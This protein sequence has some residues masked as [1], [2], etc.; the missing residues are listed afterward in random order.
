MQAIILA[1]GLGTRLREFHALPKGFLT[2][3]GQTLVSL[4][5]QH[6]LNQTIS[7][8]LIITGYGFEHYNQLAK[9]HPF[10]TTQ[11]NNRFDTY[12]NLYSLFLAKDWV[13]QDVLILESD[14]LYESR[15]LTE[16]VDNSATN[17]ILTSGFTQSGDEV[18]V[19]ALDQALTNMSKNKQLLAGT[20][21]MGEFVGITKLCVQSF[22]YLIGQ[23]EKNASLLHN[24][25]YDEHGLVELAAHH[26]ILCVQPPDLLWAEIDCHAHYMRAQRVYAAIQTRVNHEKNDFIEP[27]ASYHDQ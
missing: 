8:I 6:L 20:P 3:G 12:G 2:F 17:A 5:L 11:Y 18:Y 13:Q 15:A 1:A 22:R 21:I 10:L 24:G 27:R 26:P 19:T 7:E 4:S 25:H 23:L 9:Q 14:I 16:I